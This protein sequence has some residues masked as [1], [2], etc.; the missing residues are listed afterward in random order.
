MANFTNSP[1]TAPIISIPNPRQAPPPMLV[2]PCLLLNSSYSHSN[3]CHS[4]LIKQRAFNPPPE[5]LALPSVLSNGRYSHPLFM[6]FSCYRAIY[7]W[8]AKYE[9]FLQLCELHC[10]WD[11]H[12]GPA[13]LQV[14]SIA[15]ISSFVINLKYTS[16]STQL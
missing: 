16:R 4:A 7:L 3:P 9:G 14:P 11:C 12:I 6:F 13:S 1:K 8:W 5:L 10:S 15:T 2:F